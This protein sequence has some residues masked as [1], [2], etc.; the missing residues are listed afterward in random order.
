MLLFE[1]IDNG[2]KKIEGVSRRK[3]FLPTVNISNYKVLID[4]KNFSDQP[5]NGQYDEM[6]KIARGQVD[7]YTTGCFVELWIFQG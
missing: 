5:I 6:R 1:N 4:G 7:D 3:Y 2:A